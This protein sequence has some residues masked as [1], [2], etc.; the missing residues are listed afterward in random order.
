M[1]VLLKPDDHYGQV[2]GVFDKSREEI[3]KDLNMKEEEFDF[4]FELKSFNVNDYS[5]YN[6]N[7]KPNFKP[8]FKLYV[9]SSQ[10]F[11]GYFNNS[12]H[13][14]YSANLGVGDNDDTTI[15][16]EEEMHFSNGYTLY[17]SVPVTKFKNF[18]DFK[19]QFDIKVE[20]AKSLGYD[21]WKNLIGGRRNSLKIDPDNMVEIK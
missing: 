10:I 3:L 7:F 12:E 11:N 15:V 16:Y 5:N 21:Y 8:N 13:T 6:E 2:I 19:K 9:G 4:F 18:D 1:Y 14:M 17:W 20:K